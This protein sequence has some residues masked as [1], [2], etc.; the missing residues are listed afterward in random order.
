MHPPLEIV[1]IET[2]WQKIIRFIKKRAILT[3]IILDIIDVV[4]G[5]FPFLNTGWD[6]ITYLVLYK[7]LHNKHFSHIMI[8]EL[9]LPG[10][11][12]FAQIDAF[13]PLAI[14]IALVDYLV[15][16]YTIE[17]GRVVKRVK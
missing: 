2:R 13:I 5:N 4:A 7:F 9:L 8:I 3:A 14:I 15:D 11:E 16:T 10:N 6:I 17:F 1:D 12:I